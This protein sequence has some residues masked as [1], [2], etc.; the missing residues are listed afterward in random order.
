MRFMILLGKIFLNGFSILALL[1]LLLV[2]VIA[3]LGGG[4]AAPGGYLHW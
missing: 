2:S 1:P 4:H 3:S